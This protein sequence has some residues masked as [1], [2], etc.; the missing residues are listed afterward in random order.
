MRKL[1]LESLQV[2]S[3]ETTALGQD[4]RGTVQGHAPLTVGCPG[5]GPSNCAICQPMTNDLNCQPM[6][7]DLRGCETNPQW[8]CTYGCTQ[9]AD[10]NVN[11]CG[12]V[13]WINTTDRVCPEG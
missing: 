13:C 12:E 6:T 8:D 9:T 5:T 2:E 10:P 11:S 1:T 7:Y 3:F 4:V